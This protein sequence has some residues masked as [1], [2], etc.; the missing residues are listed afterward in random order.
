MCMKNAY[1]EKTKQHF[2]K[3][4]FIF[5]STLHGLFEVS[6]CVRECIHKHVPHNVSVNDAPH[7]YVMVVP[8]YT[9]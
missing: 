7:T 4:K 6:L 5:N 8:Y 9:A 2:A 3:K 1:Y